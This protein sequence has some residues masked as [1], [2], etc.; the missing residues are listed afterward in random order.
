MVQEWFRNGN[1]LL[2]WDWNSL[3]GAHCYLDKSYITRTFND[4]QKM[5]LYDSNLN[6]SIFD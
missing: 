5:G 2:K 6:T 4:K 1:E 3:A